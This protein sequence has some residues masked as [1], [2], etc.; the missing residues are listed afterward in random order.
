M[1]WAS[2]LLLKIR[3]GGIWFGSFLLGGSRR[4]WAVCGRDQQFFRLQAEPLNGGV[5]PG[6]FF[7][8]KLLPLALQQQIACPGINEHPAASP[9]LHQ[10]FVHQ[11][12]IPLENRERIDP[13]LGP[14]IAYRRQRTAFL[15][16]ALEDHR[17]H[18]VA[19]PAV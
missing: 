8:K 15:E 7:A 2:A 18:A 5:D 14:D 6:P 16:H 17:Y 1:A 19:K 3:L 12:L 11:L 10:P 13:I 4:R 9:G